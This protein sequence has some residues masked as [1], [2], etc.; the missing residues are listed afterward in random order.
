MH[1]VLA[2][3]PPGTTEL[4]NTVGEL[5]F[6][7]QA[8]LVMLIA[9]VIVVII[10]LVIFSRQKSDT[11][12]VNA[13][14][15]TLDTHR[16]SYEE[17]AKSA[18]RESQSREDQT[19]QFL[20][21]LKATTDAL[22]SMKEKDQLVQ[23]LTENVPYEINA[24][25]SAVVDTNTIF[26]QAHQE[27]R[28]TINEHAD[29]LAQQVLTE[30]QQISAKID[31]NNPGESLA[32]IKSQLIIVQAQIAI[33]LKTQKG[34][35]DELKTIDPL[36]NSTVNLPPDSLVNGNGYGAEHDTKPIASSDGSAGGSPGDD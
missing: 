6:A 4:V 24:V 2:Q 30:L 25:K 17:L 5:S 27:T 8:I 28:A 1:L 34:D 23:L 18:K 35:T 26:A 16:E 9:L 13:L 32:S 3:I 22:V 36:I 11:A 20:T 29:G 14:V 10:A 21:G 15:K 31:Q 33:A 12:I 19:N 7:A